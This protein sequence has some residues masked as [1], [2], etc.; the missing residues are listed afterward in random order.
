M[1]ALKRSLRAKRSTPSNSTFL[2]RVVLFIMVGAL[3]TYSAVTWFALLSSNTTNR[4]ARL[5]QRV[6]PLKFCAPRVQKYV[7]ETDFTK[8]QCPDKVWEWDEIKKHDCK[9][10]QGVHQ[11]DAWLVISHNVYNLSRFL[12][13]HPGGDVLCEATR[14]DATRVYKNLHATCVNYLLPQ[15]CIGHVKDLSGSEEVEYSHLAQHSLLDDVHGE[16]SH[17]HNH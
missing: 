15:F 10:D 11:Y 8:I 6:E 14:T 12:P 5:D 7:K 9:D 1:R 4:I 3:F 16:H 17:G 2:T 13:S